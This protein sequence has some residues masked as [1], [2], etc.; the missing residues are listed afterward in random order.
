V[1]QWGGLRRPGNYEL[2]GDTTAL[3]AIAMAGGLNDSAKHS[4]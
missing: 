3:E 4:M 1:D 2:R